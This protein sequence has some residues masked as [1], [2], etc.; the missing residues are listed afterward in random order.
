MPANAQRAVGTEGIP[1][2]RGI[3]VMI[4]GQGPF[5]FGL[6]T[7]AS[8]AFHINPKLAQSLHL[9]VVSHT[10]LHAPGESKS[11]PAPIVDVVRIDDL[12]V[13]GHTFHHALGIA[14]PSA[15]ENGGVL[16][17]ELFKDVLVSLDY[18]NDRLTISE[19]TLPI[20]DQQNVF[21]YVEDH[22]TPVL[23]V[24]LGPLNT[25]GHLD[26]GARQTKADVMVPLKLAAQLPLMEP[27]KRSGSVADAL[28]HETERYTAT[29]NGDLQIGALAFH[30]P[31]LLIS[32]W[33]SY[34]NLGGICNKLVIVLDERQ[35]RIRLTQAVL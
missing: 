23:P 32:D 26:T 13:A 14:S 19:D 31:T 21:D 2:E 15:R 35:H 6:D 24:S 29:L 7:G 4:N 16:C 9:P 22:T 17:I 25:T 33:V 1:F 10:Q 8:T 28:G 20:P 34:I 27:M 18:P 12:T 30:N 5:V 11:N 3:P